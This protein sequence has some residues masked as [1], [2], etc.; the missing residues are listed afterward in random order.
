LIVFGGPFAA[1]SYLVLL[2]VP[3]TALGLACVVLGAT[4]MLTPSSPVPVHTIRAMVEGSCVN[5]EAL[6]EEFDAR[7]KA[8]YLPPRDGRVY[9]YVPLT[10]NPGAS[11][12]W[13]AMGAPLRVVTEV[14][15]EPGLLVFP[16]G[17]EVVR[18]SM[19]S[20]DAGIEEALNHV[21]VDFVEAAESVKAVRE[22]GRVV[23]D[24]KTSRVETEFPRFRMVLGSLCTSIVGCVLSTVLGV[25]L[26]VQDE[27]VDGR[28]IRV[29]FLEVPRAG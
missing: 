7:W 9:A 2:N 19:L 15:G 6:L 1:F 26:L 22:G 5:V 29:I 3:F 11:A 4:L 14:E 23:V 21:L 20:P 27:Q 12:A 25:P 17:S 18:L 8:V 28:S 24:I 10:R 13:A 16:P